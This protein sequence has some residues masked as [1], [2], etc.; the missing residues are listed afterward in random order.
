MGTGTQA[1]GC[2]Q[3][4]GL[5]GAHPGLEP[6]L[7]WDI[8]TSGKVLAYCAT[9]PA[10]YFD[11]WAE[12]TCVWRNSTEVVPPTPPSAHRPAVAGDS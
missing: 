10:P 4:V 1:L 5:E 7:I 8:D 12:A 11:H 2:Y 9:T 3:K 6:A